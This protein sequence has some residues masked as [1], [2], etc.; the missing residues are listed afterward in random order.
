MLG[1]GNSQQNLVLYE[2]VPDVEE[3]E[4]DLV[5]PLGAVSGRVTGPDGAPLADARVTLFSGGGPQSGAVLG[6]NYGEVRTDAEGR[7]RISW[8]QP[9]RFNVGAGGAALGGMWGDGSRHGRVVRQGIAVG[10]GEDVRVDFELATSGGVE[11]LVRDTAGAA[12]AGAV[13]FVQ[14]EDGASL[15]PFSTITSD[16]AGRFRYEGLAPGRYLVSARGSAH[17]SGEAQSVDV[18]SGEP[19]RVTLAVEEGALLVVSTADE[20]G[21]PLPAALSVVDERGREVGQLR[22][23]A[24]LME[25]FSRGGFST[26]EQRVGPLAPGS[27]RVTATAADGRESTKPVTL[28]AG[29]DA[30]KLNLRLR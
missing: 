16:A 30:R 19:T 5:V 26:T 27:Y 1:A 3:H 24:E 15:E 12:V 25:L 17:A 9:G 7:Y 14:G 11:G 28:R 21:A 22:S 13:V 20:D 18:D 4:L 6:G 23:L 29:Q 8:L 10:E 2:T